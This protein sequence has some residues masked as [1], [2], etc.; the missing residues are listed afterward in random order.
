MGIVNITPDSFSD[1]GHF[2]N[3]DLALRHIETLI[4]QGAD[5]IDIGAESTRPGA[6]PVSTKDELS[7][8][9]PILTLYHQYF[10]TPISLDTTKADIAEFGLSHNVTYIN[11]VSGLTK[12]AKMAEVINRRNANVIVMHS[13]G[14]PK[15]MQDNPH[16]TDIIEDVLHF[17]N[18]ALAKLTTTGEIILDPGIGFG[19]T[20]EHNLTL[21]RHLNTLT[22]FQ[23]RILI[24]T[25]RKSFIGHLTNAEVT[26][27]LPGSIASAV[28]AYLNGATLF[29]VHDVAAHKQA[30]M[31]AA[32]LS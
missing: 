9:T 29:R 8:L 32:S 11:D 4:N 6:D 24:G 23:K 22:Q 26:D 1:G 31:L 17:F 14:T 16:Y 30:L 12:E 2:F 19:K 20:V 21:I 5:I 3:P 28:I 15:S 7:R 25:S 13:K 18:E 10:N 27:R